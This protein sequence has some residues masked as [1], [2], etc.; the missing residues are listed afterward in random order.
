MI[1]LRRL[2]DRLNPARRHPCPPPWEYPACAL[3]YGLTKVPASTAT[4]VTLTEPAIATTLLAVLI[5][6]ERLA[7]LG[8]TGLV[9]IAIV[10][11]SS[12]WLQQTLTST[13][14]RQRRRT[15]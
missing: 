9:I 4:P 2:I 10:L 14:P 6:G 13:S 1:F 12:P 11:A 3:G 8:W 5:V 7:T 15:P